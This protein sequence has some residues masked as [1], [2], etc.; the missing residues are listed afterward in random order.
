MTS[1]QVKTRNG[2]Q[3]FTL[4]G[5]LFLNKGN[6]GSIYRVPGANSFVVKVYKDK[7]DDEHVNKLNT[8]VANPPDDPMAPK[9][10]AS[11]AWPRDLIALAGTGEVCGFVMPLLR[12][13]YPISTF[14]NLKLRR[15]DVPNFTYKSLCRLGSNLASAVWAIH[16]KG[17]VIGDVNEGNIMATPGALAAIV[18][19]DSFQIKDA[20]TGH[21]YRCPVYTPFYTAPEFQDVSMDQVDRAPEQDLF[22]ITVL[23]FQ[24]L[25]EGHLPFQ[26][27]FANPTSTPDTVEWLKQGYFP[28]GQALSGI[29]APPG[30]PPY[31]ALHPKLQQLFNLCFIDGHQDPRMRP[32]AETWRRALLESEAYLTQCTANSQHYYFNHLNACHWCEQK[33]RVEAVKKGNWDPFPQRGSFTAGPHSRPSGTQR[34]ISIPA[35]APGVKPPPVPASPP[36][37]FTASATSIAPGQPITFQWTVP[38]AHTVQLKE[39]SGRVVS[40]SYSPSG[41]VTVWPTKSKTYQLT[42][43]GVNAV[44]PPPIA[45]SVK[46]PVPVALK[47]IVVELKAPVE[48]RSAQLAL[49]Q[50]LPLRQPA[51]SLLSPMRLKDHIQ[52]D[53]YQ[54]LNDVTVDLNYA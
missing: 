51:M 10:H 35:P 22:G 46:Q 25:M 48:L 14:Y 30:A 50:T 43:K 36:I 54:P 28:Y 3:T 18:D 42:A 41:S 1:W 26:C 13:C 44:M 21:V 40:T 29:S 20:A 24:L 31:E 12:D 2:G 52:L 15:V 38:N 49:L 7:V 39:R 45:V 34:P 4:D 8:M 53:G 47:E 33:R 23:L 19:T 11:I 27:A 17:Y 37:V 9:G 6:E 5:S 16:E 32:T